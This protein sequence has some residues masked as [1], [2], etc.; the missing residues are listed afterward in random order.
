MWYYKFIETKHIKTC[1]LT[2]KDLELI[3]ALANAETLVEA[4]SRLSTTQSALSH[5]LKTLESKIESP[6][7]VRPS[8]P[9]KLTNIGTKIQRSADEIL[10]RLQRLDEDIH[11]MLRGNIGRLRI[12]IECHS[13]YQWLM[14][15]LNQYRQ[16]WSEIELDIA[17]GDRFD[18]M[19]ALVDQDIDL[20]VTSDPVPLAN[21]EYIPLF[22][23]QCVVTAPNDHPLSN[24]PYFE[25]EDF[26]NETLIT[27]PVSRNRMDVFRLFLSP[28]GVEPLHIRQ[29]ELTMMSIQLVASGRGLFALPSW[30][31]IEFTEPGYVQEKKLG[32]EGVTSTLYAAV[33]RQSL[34]KEYIRDFIYLAKDISLS[35]LRNIIANPAV[36]AG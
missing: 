17:G 25:A 21:I 31:A 26:Y 16:Q 18:T 34:D 10:P 24:K 22:D 7:V 5:Q 14:P 32:I 28:A 33:Q 35:T 20:V 29:V 27:Y 12:G 30:A 3:N 9:L 13:C 19:Q 2:S 15:T 11:S 6:V 4:A 36:L 23:Y 8:K 1:M